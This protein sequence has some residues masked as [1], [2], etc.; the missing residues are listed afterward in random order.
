MEAGAKVCSWIRCGLR[1]K[2]K[3]QEL[4]QGSWSEKE[5]ALKMLCHCLLFSRNAEEFSAVFQII[6]PPN[7][8]KKSPEMEKQPTM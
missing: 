6:V 7:V 5:E 3:N 2:Q 8:R 1:E 4:L